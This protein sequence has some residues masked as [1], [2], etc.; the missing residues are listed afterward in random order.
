MRRKDRE[1]DKEFAL[2]V[3]D[4]CKY[5]V[6]SVI[7]PENKPYA[8][9]L[10]MVRIENNI[11]FHCALEGKKLDALNYN[12]NVCVVCVGDT[13]PIPQK[14]TMEYESAIIEGKAERVSDVTEK[15]AALKAI[16]IKY[17]PENI[18]AFDTYIEKSIRVTDIWKISMDKVTAKCN[19]CL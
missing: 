14:F 15:K 5:S 12:P 19:K 9:P 18:K 7:S 6:L 3:I 10:S 13:M 16:V 11:Y 1:M 2:K 4:K 8:V 17:T